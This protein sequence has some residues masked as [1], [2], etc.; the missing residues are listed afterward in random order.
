[1]CQ[2]HGTLRGI[3]GAGMSQVLAEMAIWLGHLALLM[4]VLSKLKGNNNTHETL[5]SQRLFQQPLSSLVKFKGWFLYFLLDLLL[6]FLFL[7]SVLQVI[8]GWCGMGSCGSVR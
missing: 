1:M 8:S 7:F 6:W 4:S 3:A 2:I 5:Q